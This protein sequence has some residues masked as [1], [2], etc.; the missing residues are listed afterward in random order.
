MVKLY[1][2][3]EMDH[4]AGIKLYISHFN[5]D[6]DVYRASY[7]GRRIIELTDEQADSFVHQ[8]NKDGGKYTAYVYDSGE[9]YVSSCKEV[10]VQDVYIV[11]EKIRSNVSTKH[12]EVITWEAHVKDRDKLV[13]VIEDYISLHTNLY[14][15]EGLSIKLNYVKDLQLLKYFFGN[16]YKYDRLVE[17]SGVEV[18]EK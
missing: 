4:Q 7:D 3:D 9:E 12:T 18:V 11:Q 8:L 16:I 2:Q 14:G 5:T 15:V 13:R 1:I 6:D 17:L 10:K